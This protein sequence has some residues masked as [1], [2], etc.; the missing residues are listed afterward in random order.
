MKSI[1]IQF[2]VK[3]TN[4]LSSTMELLKQFFTDGILLLANG[5]AILSILKFIV[6]LI[7]GFA[8]KSY[9]G[10]SAMDD[11]SFVR[12]TNWDKTITTSSSRRGENLDGSFK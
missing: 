11:T 1:E 4:D 2:P 5:I 9:M 3:S 8:T 6:G 10:S 7:N 12:R